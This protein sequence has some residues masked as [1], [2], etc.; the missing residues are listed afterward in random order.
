MVTMMPPGSLPG[1]SSLASA[2]TIKPM[3][4]MAMMCI[5]GRPPA[6]WREQEAGRRAL[7]APGRRR[8]FGIR[9]ET[10][11]VMAID[12]M[13]VPHDTRTTVAAMGAI[14]VIAAILIFLMMSLVRNVGAY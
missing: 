6:S 12:R 14:I 10:E 3:M 5:G 4:S 2:P 1:M 8:T 11:D 9:N 7:A 13:H